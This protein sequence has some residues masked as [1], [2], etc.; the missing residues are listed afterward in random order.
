MKEPDRDD[1]EKLV[2]SLKYINGTLYLKL[3]LYVDEMAFV[4]W[5]IDSSYNV[6]HNASG[7]SNAMMSLGKGAVISASNK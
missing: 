4:T 2:R 6:H 1:W 7:H 5:W 3:S